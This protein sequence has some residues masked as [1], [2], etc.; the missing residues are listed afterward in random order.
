MTGVEGAARSVRDVIYGSICC[1]ATRPRPPDLVKMKR[2]SE[3]AAWLWKMCRNFF[4]YFLIYVPFPLPESCQAWGAGLEGG[5]AINSAG[6][7]HVLRHLHRLGG[8]DQEEGQNPGKGLEE[9]PSR[10]SPA[11]KFCPKA[12][13]GCTKSSMSALHNFSPFPLKKH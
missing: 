12:V 4:F 2:T 1:R 8:R 5:F 13:K 3:S 7:Q 9:C 10:C 6:V 11:C